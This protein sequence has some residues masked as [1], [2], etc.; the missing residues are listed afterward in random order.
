MTDWDR[1]LAS[2]A[3]DA[4]KNCIH[5]FEAEYP[6]DSRPRRALEAAE[7]WLANPTRENRQSLEGLE[8]PLWRSKDW[9]SGHA[10]LAAQAC[11]LAGQ[12]G[13]SSP[14]LGNARN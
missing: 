6:T 9:G 8:I 7:K 2:I 13:P 12:S 14:D 1:M 4:A 3:I 10:S 11:A 5:V